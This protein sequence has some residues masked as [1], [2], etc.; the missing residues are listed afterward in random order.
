MNKR[1]MK[2]L[3]DAG[4]KPSAILEALKKTHPNE[5]IL[6]TISTIY[7]ARKK[8]QNQILQGISPI[9]HL[10]QTLEKSSF[11]T[12]TKVNENGKLAI[13]LSFSVHQSPQ[14]LPLCPPP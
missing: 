10:N 2:K 7:A 6:A 11:T 3:G 13:F 8:S 5:T 1:E 14:V 4:L 9:F 12:A